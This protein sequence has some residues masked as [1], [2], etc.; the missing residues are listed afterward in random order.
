MDQIP[1]RLRIISRSG[2]EGVYYIACAPG[3]VQA[4]GNKNLICHFQAQFQLAS[5]SLI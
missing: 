4:H 5:S 1:S 2:G 3:S